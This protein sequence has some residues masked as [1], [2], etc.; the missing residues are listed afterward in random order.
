MVIREGC[1]YLRGEFIRERGHG[2]LRLERGV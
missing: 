2:V 1:A